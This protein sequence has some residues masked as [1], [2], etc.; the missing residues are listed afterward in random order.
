MAQKSKQKRPLDKSSQK[1]M[2]AVKP[3]EAVEPAS[4]PKTDPKKPAVPRFIRTLFWGIACLLAVVV[5]YIYVIMIPSLSVKPIYVMKTPN[6]TAP[7]PSLLTSAEPADFLKTTPTDAGTPSAEEAKAVSDETENLNE[8]VIEPMIEEKETQ[9]V[10]ALQEELETLKSTQNKTL[11]DTLTLY[12]LMANGYPYRSVLQK[13]LAADPQNVFAVRVQKE[14]AAFELTGIPTLTQLQHMYAQDAKMAAYSFYVKKEP[15]TWQE[16]IRAFLKSLVQIRPTHITDSDLTGP[17]ILY[18]AQDELNAGHLQRAVDLLQKLP[19]E[20]SVLMADFIR[21]A[22][23]RMT[24][25]QIMT[26]L[27]REERN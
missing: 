25:N 16:N 27:I 9:T 13:V 24:L 3:T 4:P 2:P 23:A 11:I 7:V 6:T 20:Q 26:S 18:K 5:L 22:S 21:N 19:T 14:L 17:K 12:H 15:M 8:T 1:P 10:S